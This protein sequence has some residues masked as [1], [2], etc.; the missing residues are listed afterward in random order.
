MA[1][2]FKKG[3]LPPKLH[4]K[5]LRLSKYLAAGMLP[6]PATKVYREYKV[7]VD[8]KQ[9]FG[10]DTVGD[11][12]FAAI[13]NLIVLATCHT[14]TVV[15]PTVEQ[16]LAV[17]SAVTGYDPSQ[18][19]PDGSNPTDNGAAMTDILAYMQKVGMAGH[20]ILGWASINFMNRT[21]RNLGVDLFAATYVGVNLPQSAEDQFD[22]GQNFE[23][24]SGSPIVGGHAIL[25][26]GYGALG[27]DYVTWA[28]WDQKASLG[29]SAK[30]VE[31]EYVVITEDW[32][33]QVTQKTPGGLDLATLEADLKLVSA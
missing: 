15:I 12:T 2:T 18:N 19:Q 4:P 17:Y 32:I 20:K 28:K 33:N 9:M 5:T 1:F 21:Y 22:A 27:D 13:A 29:W 8:A 24:V 25:H 26:A 11:C 3:K 6:S 31:E 14:G 16:V 30:Y 23:L 7:P 10:N